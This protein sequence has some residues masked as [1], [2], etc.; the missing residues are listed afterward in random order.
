MFL[1][2][3]MYTYRQIQ[4]N[5]SGIIYFQT[6]SGKL[7]AGYIEKLKKVPSKRTVKRTK[8]ILKVDEE[9]QMKKLKNVNCIS[10]LLENHEL[11]V[12]SGED[13]FISKS[14]LETKIIEYG[15]SVVQ[16][17]GTCEKLSIYVTTVG[18]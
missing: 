8:E 2:S 1:I 10:T 6:F 12:L 14:E 16:N 18:L 5:L 13:N 3:K 15:G 4:Y 11:C 17:P 7:T 9:C